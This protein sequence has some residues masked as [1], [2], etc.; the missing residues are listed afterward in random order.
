MILFYLG[1]E[2]C[3][4]SEVCAKQELFGKKPQYRKIV[5]NVSTE[6]INKIKN[7]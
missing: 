1:Y 6:K 4:K 5:I 2:F 7:S 3:I